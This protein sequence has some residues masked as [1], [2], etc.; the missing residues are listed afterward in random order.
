[1]LFDVDGGTEDDLIMVEDFSLPPVV[2]LRAIAGV[3]VFDF[4]DATDVDRD[5]E[6]A[7][8][9]EIVGVVNAVVAD[10]VDR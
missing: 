1:M 8:Y 6:V 10:R 4:L 7:E 5:D 9:L 3:S 2:L